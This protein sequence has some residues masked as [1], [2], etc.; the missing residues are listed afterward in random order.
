MQSRIQP[1][2]P[3]EMATRTKE[4]NMGWGYWEGLEYPKNREDMG[5]GICIALRIRDNLI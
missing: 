3:L 5:F 2:Q 1:S 4:V